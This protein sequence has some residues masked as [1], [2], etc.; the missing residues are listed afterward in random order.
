MP[1]R[2]GYLKGMP[3]KTVVLQ[4]LG[5]L[6]GVYSNTPSLFYDETGKP[7]TNGSFIRLPDGRLSR[8]VAIQDRL[9]A[10]VTGRDHR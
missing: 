4:N 3:K 1:H 2:P 6:P 7:D 10:M 5:E 8:A 9:A